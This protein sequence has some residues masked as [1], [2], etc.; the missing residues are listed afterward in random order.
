MS[1]P[2]ESSVEMRPRDSLP[3]GHLYMQ[4]NETDN[5]VIHYHRYADGT[6]EEAGAHGRL[7]FRGLQ[8]SE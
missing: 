1:T 2:S 4:T 5:A 7:R 8:L 6:L 3:Q